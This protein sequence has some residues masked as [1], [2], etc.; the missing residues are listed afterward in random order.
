MCCLLKTFKDSKTELKASYLQGRSDEPRKACLPEV[1]R[2][3]RTK[4]RCPE[5]ADV[6]RHDAAFDR[7]RTAF[8]A[9]SAIWNGVSGTY[10][11][12]EYT[13]G[14]HSNELNHCDSACRYS[15][16]PFLSPAPRQAH[17]HLSYLQYSYVEQDGTYLLHL[18]AWPGSRTREPAITKQC[19]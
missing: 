16:L 4:L 17:V 10:G 8:R 5:S 9:L 11:G 13:R 18:H 7:G 15:T 19:E 1:S 12:S 14:D 2:K 6:E 3:E